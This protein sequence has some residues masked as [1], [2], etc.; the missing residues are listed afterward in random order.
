MKIE[1]FKK[2]NVMP[3]YFLNYN[4]VVNVEKTGL[5]RLLSNSSKEKFKRQYSSRPFY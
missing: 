4:I 1:T 2:V 5:I 3:H